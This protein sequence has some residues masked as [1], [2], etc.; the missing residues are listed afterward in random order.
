MWDARLSLNVRF[1]HPAPLAAG[2]CSVIYCLC[3][4]RK[5]TY[6]A[7]LLSNSTFACYSAYS[8]FDLICEFAPVLQTH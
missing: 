1:G 4:Y 6:T 8:A 2:V 7:N 5:Y 3:Q